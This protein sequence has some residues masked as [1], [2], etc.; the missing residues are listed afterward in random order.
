MNTQLLVYSDGKLTVMSLAAEQHQWPNDVKAAL[1]SLQRQRCGLHV[2]AA[3]PDRASQDD[4]GRFCGAAGIAGTDGADEADATGR[5]DSGGPVH[6][7]TA[8]YVTGRMAGA[9]DAASLRHSVQEIRVTGHNAWFSLEARE[10]YVP[11]GNPPAG[12]IVPALE[13]TA[14]RL[15][16]WVHDGVLRQEGLTSAGRVVYDASIDT[17][18]TSAGEHTTGGDGV[19]YR[20]KTWW[21]T[22]S[23][24]GVGDGNPALSCRN[25]FVPVAIGVPVDWATQLRAAAAC[26]LYRVVGRQ[27]VNGVRAIKLE[28]VIQ[29]RIARADGQTFW[30][31]PSTY[32]PLRME[33]RG[34]QSSVVSDFRWLPPTAANVAKVQVPI[35]AGFTKVAPAGLPEIGWTS[36]VLP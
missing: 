26:G 24:F 33:S 22:V 35:P 18:T 36:K 30:V 12:P 11:P 4:G 14:R 8:A 23:R 19:D 1:L 25:V 6:A 3:W 17:V 5:R 34:S 16:V 9:L 27:L 2:V 15:D 31:D 29:G 21:H 13:V 7:Q 20:N 32:L 10:L 28:M